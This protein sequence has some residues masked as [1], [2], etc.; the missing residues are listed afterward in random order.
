MRKRH[1]IYLLAPA[2]VL[3]AGCADTTIDL[4]D[5]EK[6]QSIAQYEYLD[7]YAPL[8]EY[9]NRNAHPGFLLASGVSASDYN[10]KGLVYRLTNSNFDEMTAG[11]EMKYAS[12]VNDQ[13]NM[14][15]ST[16]SKFVENARNA[17]MK[18]YGHTLCWHEQQN[19]KWLNSLIADKELEVDPGAMEEKEDARTVFAN[20]T[21][22]P[23]YVMGY[24]PQIQDGCLVSYNPD[25]WHQYFVMDGLSTEPGRTYTITAKMCGTEDGKVNV[26]FGNWGELQEATL[27]FSTEMKEY[28]VTIDG[29]TTSSSFVVFQPGTYQGEI[30]IE[31][32]KLTHNEAPV[33]ELFTSI[34]NNGDAE[35]DDL[36]NFIS[37]EQ[38]GQSVAPCLIGEAGSGADG[39]GH[40]FVVHS[41][42]SP[43]NT[44][45]TQFFIMGNKVLHEGDKIHVA[46][47]YKADK[48]AGSESQTHSTPGNYIHWD[49]GL[50]VTFT[51]EWQ[52]FEK[53]M[54]I[55]ASQAGENG[56]Q[57]FAF[58]LGVLPETN[59]YYFDDI[60]FDIVTSANTLPLTDEEKAEILTA[61]ME[62]WVK[63]MMEATEGYVTSWDVVNEAISGGPWGQRYDLQHAATASGDQSNKF[64][65]QDYLG[66]NFVRVPIRF[67][68]KY[69]EENGGNPADLKLFINDYNLESDWDNNQKLKS[70]IQW[71][72][73]WE[74]DGET[75]IDGIGT[76]MH[77]TYYM[78]PQ[79]QASKEKHVEEMFRLMAASGK[80]VRISELDMGIADENGNTLSTSE[81]TFEQEKL[82]AGYYEFI[83]KKY[84]EIIPVSQQYGICQ[85]AQTDS[86]EGSG[87]R[88]GEPIGLWNL[89]FQRKPTYE[90]YVKGLSEN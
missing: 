35:G 72:E 64:Y 85:W 21:S 87:W 32:V 36:T 47:K 62:R 9:I 79:T 57:T 1:L 76:Q 38:N 3:L 56:M 63:G 5:V 40:A 53:T 10:N 61:E 60:E 69:F 80:L 49:G 65:W 18:I 83:I 54:T 37:T 43:A 46:F 7:A 77:V 84:F 50:A 67:A 52:Q 70:L 11:N 26:Q 13:G 29:V 24:E 14:D 44:W 31:Y 51:T 19:V 33:M 15:F 74:S 78:N 34:I 66:D 86:P 75:K 58:N 22:F 16:V 55:D 25:E 17:G 12:I 27:S 48:G 23:F 89:D 68:R 81:I 39:V 42:N 90:G 71:I 73:Q 88:S 6:P 4:I 45:D 20:Y 41:G 59:T 8:K 30:K 2:G 82:M 28:S